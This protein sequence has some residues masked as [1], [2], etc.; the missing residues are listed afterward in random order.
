M[1]DFEGT[2][3]EPFINDPRMHGKPEEKLTLLREALTI[4]LAEEPTA[5]FLV[6]ATMH[7]VEAIVK[8]ATLDMIVKLLTMT[9]EYLP[10]LISDDYHRGGVVALESV[11]DVFRY[12]FESEKRRYAQIGR[13]LDNATRI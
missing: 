7:K 12:T 6:L 1:K 9:G 3:L 11:A 4:A 8:L 5:L 2:P 10:H 13:E